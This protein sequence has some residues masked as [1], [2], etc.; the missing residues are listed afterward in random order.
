MTRRATTHPTSFFSAAL[1][2]TVGL[3]LVTFSLAFTT[4]WLGATAAK[5]ATTTTTITLPQDQN[6]LYFLIWFG[7]VSVVMII[8][9]R[10][11]SS[12]TFWKAFFILGSIAGIY[13][14][15]FAI[16]SSF[17]SFAPAAIFSLFFAVLIL[18]AR[19]K[20]QWI[21]LHNIT[22]ILALVGVSRIFGYEFSPSSTAF[23]L[24]V[25]AVYDLL[26]VYKTKQMVMMAETFLAHR[27]FFGVVL[28]A[29]L[30]DWCK[31]LATGHNG[32]NGMVIGGGD[33]GLPLFFAMSHLYYNG[34]AA[35]VVI[36]LATL[37]GVVLLQLIYEKVVL[38]K[39]MPGLPPLVVCALLGHLVIIYIL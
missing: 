33:I 13:I 22:V 7:V 15:F 14:V 8:L 31:P 17:L 2:Q 28:P 35:F 24:I 16:E 4:S 11:I 12:S 6:P 27:S 19:Q 20:T 26:V 36:M 3:Y 38:K 37:V 10:R 23:I 25:L 30:R 29:R 32:A 18:I 21:W 1:A 5:T 34:I 9:L 39:P